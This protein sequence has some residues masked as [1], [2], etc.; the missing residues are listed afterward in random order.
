VKTLSHLPILSNKA[1]FIVKKKPLMIANRNNSW[2]IPIFYYINLMIFLCF[3]QL[4][5]N[6][7]LIAKEIQSRGKRL[8]S[9]HDNYQETTKNLF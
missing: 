3:I 1:S 2:K 5:H 9:F 7:V 8:K 4:E 6:H